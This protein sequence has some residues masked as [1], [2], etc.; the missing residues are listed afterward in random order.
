MNVNV[1]F[2]GF[3]RRLNQIDATLS[4][5]SWKIVPLEQHGSNR[6]TDR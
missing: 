6:K 5:H 4:M 1:I 2:L 3:L